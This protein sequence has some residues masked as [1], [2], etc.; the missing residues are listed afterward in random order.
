MKSGKKIKKKF[1]M[2]EDEEKRNIAESICGIANH[3]NPYCF[4]PPLITKVSPQLLPL[5]QFFITDTK[6]FNIINESTNKSNVLKDICAKIQNSIDISVQLQNLNKLILQIFNQNFPDTEEL[7]AFFIDQSELGDLFR[8]YAPT[9]ESGGVFYVNAVITPSHNNLGECVKRE[10]RFIQ[11]PYLTFHNNLI[12]ENAIKKVPYIIEIPLNGTSKAM[13]YRV[14]GLIY[15]DAGNYC[16]VKRFNDDFVKF[17]KDNIN[18]ITEECFLES[19]KYKWIYIFYEKDE[20]I[21][22][23][24]DSFRL[25]ENTEQIYNKRITK[26]SDD[27]FFNFV[28]PDGTITEDHPDNQKPQLLCRK[29][30]ALVQATSSIIKHS[31]FDKQDLILQNINLIKEK[32]SNDKSAY[33]E[34]MQILEAALTKYFDE[35]DENMLNQKNIYEYLSSS[36]LCNFPYEDLNRKSK[37]ERQDAESSDDDPS[38]EIEI[39]D[40]ELEEEE[41]DGNEGFVLRDAT[42]KGYKVRYALHSC[43]LTTS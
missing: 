18:Y 22:K 2:A 5:I 24:S 28:V 4:Y 1:Q 7:L 21:T 8:A 14:I 20:L 41:E 37:T 33:T 3:P 19:I 42:Q 43:L 34:D 36:H 35:N 32:I 27:Y 26:Q 38:Q 15:E 39:E 12:N 30:N 17:E 16:L 13:L 11:P 6:I 29:M 9:A 40:I 25:I 10:Q 31:A 23:D